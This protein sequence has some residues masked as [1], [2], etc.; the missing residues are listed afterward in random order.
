MWEKLNWTANYCAW[1]Q[2]FPDWLFVL[3]RFFTARPWKTLKKTDKQ[4]VHLK[5]LNL[6]YL[7]FKLKEKG[8]KDPVKRDVTLQYWRR[9][10]FT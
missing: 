1:S 2:N 5:K 9:S 3:I 10:I 7:T 8:T 4:I 6:S